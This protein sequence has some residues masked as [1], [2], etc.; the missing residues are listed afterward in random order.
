MDIK[1]IGISKKFRTFTALDS[2]NLD[3]YQRAFLA[4]TG[5]SGSGKTTLLSLITGL[6]R[7]TTGKV[8][9]DGR[10][11]GPLS[12]YLRSSTLRDRISII[13]QAPVLLRNLTARDNTLFP[14]LAG[15]RRRKDLK[16]RYK[17]LVELFGFGSKQNHFPF[18]LSGGEVQKV[19]VMRALLKPSDI[20]I[21]DEPTRDLDA[22]TVERL[23]P[24]FQRL[25]REGMTIVMASHNERLTDIAKDR[26]LLQ[27]G[28]LSKK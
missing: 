26:F 1:L 9:F 5:D 13:F 25:N 6:M 7:P 20:L 23:R 17:E 28:R 8:F 12:F 19:A 4:V 21:A 2:I 15:R 3:I 22:A 14:Y 16:Q 18:Q 11:L 10:L 24:L 27:A